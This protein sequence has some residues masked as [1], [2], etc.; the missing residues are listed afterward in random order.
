MKGF[1]RPS[2]ETGRSASVGSME[3]GAFFGALAAAVA[4]Q[5]M[6]G[7]SRCGTALTAIRTCPIQ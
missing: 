7:P 6:L 4:V 5:F 1:E 3:G 2:H